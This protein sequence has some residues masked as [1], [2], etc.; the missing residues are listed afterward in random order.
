MDTDQNQST[1]NSPRGGRGITIAIIVIIIIAI[2][3]FIWKI[4]SGTAPT[5]TTL[6]GQ[7]ADNT[8]PIGNSKKTANVSLTDSGFSPAS[9]TIHAGDTVVFTNNSQGR[10]WVASDPHPTHTDYP[11][12]D[13]KSAAVSGGS[14]S[15]TFTRVGSWGY[16]NH[17]NPATRGTVVVK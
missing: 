3:F 4:A 6:P 9:I 5:T 1:T 11:G 2:I 12:F 10:M 8:Q 14:Y 16:H 13:E 17:L 15:F 7:F